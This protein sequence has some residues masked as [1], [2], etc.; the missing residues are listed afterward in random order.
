MELEK[1]KKFIV[2]WIN[3]Y[4]KKNCIKNLIVGISGGIDSALTSTLCAMT[5]INT[6]VV[7]LPISQS[8][9]ELE[10][11]IKHMNWLKAN[12]QNIQTTTIELSEVLATYQ[13]IIPKNYHSDLGFANTR[14]RI[15]MM[16]LYQI[17]STHNGIV[18][19]TGNKIE[20]FG[21]GFFTK[22]GDG[23]VDISPI[24][25]LTKSEVRKLA[26]FCG[27]IPGII[28]AKPTDGLW[29]DGRTDED[30]IG[31]TYEELEWAMDFQSNTETT[32]R[33][34]K[35]LNIYKALNNKNK[36]KMVP[37]PI[38]KIPLKKKKVN[39]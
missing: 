27:I 9:N 4:A 21:I 31:A 14:A 3:D 5:G 35:V 13:N 24:A 23:G 20:D 28:T 25:D 30:Q 11:A 33:E 26:K 19:G 12:Y 38:C 8:K 36:H 39:V 10:N 16:T 2:Q 17:A 1:I 6:K 7:S 18:V 32:N 15:R 29:K 34:K 22:Y 37:I